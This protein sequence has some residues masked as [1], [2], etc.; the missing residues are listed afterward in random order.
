MRNR[1][2]F[3]FVFNGRYGVVPMNVPRPCNQWIV[4]LAEDLHHNRQRA[5]VTWLTGSLN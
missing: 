1:Y 4:E 5:D 2:Q 3:R